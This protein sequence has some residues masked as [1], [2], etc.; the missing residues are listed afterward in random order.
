ML[1]GAFILS[2]PFMLPAEAA[3]R[4]AREAE[5][6]E[7][8]LKLKEAVKSSDLESLKR[9][10]L[11]CNRYLVFM[12][13]KH[14]LRLE[15]ARK[16]IEL[17]DPMLSQGHVEAMMEAYRSLAWEKT[18]EGHREL[19]SKH[20][21]RGWE[22]AQRYQRKNFGDSSQEDTLSALAQYVFILNLQSLPEASRQQVLEECVV[23]DQLPRHPYERNR[24]L[25]CE[26]AYETYIQM[27]NPADRD[28]KVPQYLKDRWRTD[29]RTQKKESPKSNT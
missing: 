20:V 26:W 1:G 3:K 14:Q 28:P 27:Q 29:E 15:A 16:L 2:A 23:R 7:D 5:E 8:Y 24:N 6:R 25:M 10:V 12:D 11:H 22:L 13:E 4:A 21:R 9:C 19:E 18:F 17:D